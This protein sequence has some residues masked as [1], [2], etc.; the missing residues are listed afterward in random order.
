MRLIHW[1]WA[2]ITGFVVGLIARAIL[3]GSDKM[4]F[5]MTMVLGI[6]GSLVGGFIGSLINKP[7]EGSQ[8]HAAG[9]FMSLIGA[10]LLL[11]LWRFIA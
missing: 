2:A 11:L 7:A 10:I 1:I 5:L 6:L 4:G 3:P 8:F 9:F